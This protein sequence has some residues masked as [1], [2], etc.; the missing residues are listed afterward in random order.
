VVGASCKKLGGYNGY[1][2]VASFRAYIGE[3]TRPTEAEDIVQTSRL[4]FWCAG[5][6]VVLCVFI[7]LGV[8]LAGGTLLWP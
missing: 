1:Y 5:A 6:F 2:G 7:T 8:W 3:A 4:M